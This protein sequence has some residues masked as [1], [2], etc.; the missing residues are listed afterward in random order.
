[1]LLSTVVLVTG[2]CQKPEHQK[3]GK[4]QSARLSEDQTEAVEGEEGTPV[5]TTQACTGD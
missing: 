3:M 1:M 5:P 4:N 2:K